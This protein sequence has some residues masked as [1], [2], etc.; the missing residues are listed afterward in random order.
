MSESEIEIIEIFEMEWEEFQDR[1]RAVDRER[2][3]D[4]WDTERC[5]T[6]KD[7]RDRER[8]FEIKR[9]TDSTVALQQET[10]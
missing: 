5:S 2:E 7:V 3:K 1:K 8:E 9:D 6:Q 4:T 10:I